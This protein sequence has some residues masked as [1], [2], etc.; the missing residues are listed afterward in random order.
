MGIDR[1]SDF[2]KNDSRSSGFMPVGNLVPSEE[3]FNLLQGAL[4]WDKYDKL[5]YVSKTPDKWLSVSPVYVVEIS[6]V[7][8]YI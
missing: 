2:L 4:H 6:P 7:K 1:Q 8:S 3:P 5:L